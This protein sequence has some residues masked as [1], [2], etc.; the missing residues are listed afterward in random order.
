[1]TNPLK[2]GEKGAPNIPSITSDKQHPDRGLDTA[3]VF[4]VPKDGT[5]NLTGSPPVIGTPH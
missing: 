2:Y 1:M 5:I 3:R 4:V